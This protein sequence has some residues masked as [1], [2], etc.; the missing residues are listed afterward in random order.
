M[1]FRNWG[2]TPR[3]FREVVITEKID[4][5][6][7]A[8]IIEKATKEGQGDAISFVHVDDTTYAV[9]A[10]SKS[11]LIYP[12]KTTDNYHFAQWVEENAEQLVRELGVGHH[13]GEWWGKG[14]QKRYDVGYR[15][16]SLFN[17]ARHGDVSFSTGFLN[18]LA[19]GVEPV[20]V[21]FEGQLSEEVVHEVAR[22]LL[23]NGSVAAPF[24]PNPEGVC[25]YHT[26]SK[27]IYKFTFDH[28]DKGKWE[29]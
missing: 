11:R 7:C 19:V 17:T 10:Q 8:V 23:K 15:T 6:N 5:T 14:I 4:G 29:Y 2:K 1:E 25:I 13:F 26:Q 16:F 28:N 18:G 21:L 9:G 22:E 20:P 27:Q 3:L 12:G 24:A